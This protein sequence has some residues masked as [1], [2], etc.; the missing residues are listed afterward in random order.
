MYVKKLHCK[1]EA[2]NCKQKTA[3]KKCVLF[4]FSNCC[5]SYH[6]CR[7]HHCCL[8]LFP[9]RAGSRVPLC[10]FDIFF[11]QPCQEGLGMLYNKSWT[12]Y[13]PMFAGTLR[14]SG[15]FVHKMALSLPS[16]RNFH[17]I[18]CFFWASR[19]TTSSLER[20]QRTHYPLYR[21][22]NITMLYIYVYIY[23]CMYVCKCIYIH[24]L[25]ANIHKVLLAGE[26]VW[27][28]ER[29]IAQSAKPNVAVLGCVGVA[30]DCHC[31]EMSRGKMARKRCHW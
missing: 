22:S 12:H 11:K 15:R 3:S 9:A 2:S 30:K 18:A 27:E 6:G 28:R 24:I 8:F 25:N 21:I 1:Q 31:S 17:K 5:D 16:Q 14:S 19:P 4:I 26:R 23:V 20:A 29:E 10:C 7:R 13:P